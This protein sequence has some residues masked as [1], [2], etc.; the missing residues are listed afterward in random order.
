MTSCDRIRREP[1]PPASSHLAEQD[2][3]ILIRSEAV[4][5]T[6]DAVANSPEEAVS[7]SKSGSELLARI[8]LRST[9]IGGFCGRAFR[10]G[11]ARFALGR[12]LRLGRCRW[13][14]VRLGGVRIG[15]AA[16][17]GDVEPRAF[18]DQSG[19]GT[20]QSLGFFLAALRALLFRLCLDGLKQFPHVIAGRALVIVSWHS[21]FQNVGHVFNVLDKKHDEIVLRKS[22]ENKSGWP[23]IAVQSRQ[24]LCSVARRDRA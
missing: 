12:G 13:R 20:N 24:S 4:D 5:L 10:L 23:T 16:I 6:A 8:A 18:E 9:G 17:V 15:L 14:S 11:T 21:W 22:G 19:T 2:T 1:I 3:A 7:F